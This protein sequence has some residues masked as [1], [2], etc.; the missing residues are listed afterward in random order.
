MTTCASVEAHASGSPRT[1]AST[2]PDKSRFRLFLKE[3]TELLESL[4]QDLADLARSA[5]KELLDLTSGGSAPTAV[6]RT[7]S[8]ME[9]APPP[10]PVPVPAPAPAPV[11]APTA[12]PP[13]LPPPSPPPAPAVDPAPAAA[14][15]APAA[16]AMAPAAPA[17]PVAPA[18]PTAPTSP[19]DAAAVSSGRGGDGGG[20][21]SR[22]GPFEMSETL[23]GEGGYGRV[24]LARHA[25][26]G[27]HVAVKMM[28]TNSPN[29][30]MREIHAMRVA[31]THEH[32]CGLRACFVSS[33]G[34]RFSLVLDLC[35]G[36]E[37]CALVNRYGALAEGDTWR[38]F[39]GMLAGVRHLHSM[40]IVHRDIKLENVLLGGPEQLTPK[41]CDF[42]LAHIYQRTADGL[43]F[44][45]VSLTQ[46]CGSRSYCPPEIMACMPYE[47]FRADLWSLAVALFAM[48][49]GFFPFEEATQRDW[50]F[51]RLAVL[52]LRG[53][54]TGEST[55]ACIYGF[56]SRPCPL[57]PALVELLDA[58][59]MLQPGRRMPLDDVATSAWVQGGPDAPARGLPPQPVAP[60]TAPDTAL[61]AGSARHGADIGADIGAAAAAMNDTFM[62]GD[63]VVNGMR[64]LEMAEVDGP[65]Y[66]E[67]RGRLGAHDG[68]HS[69]TTTAPPRLRRNK[70][71]SQ[72]VGVEEDAHDGSCDRRASARVQE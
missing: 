37:L 3:A 45:N 32:V 5:R 1:V 31:G 72:R 53:G 67:G 11:S 70:A 61:D 20:G 71:C 64:D 54:P 38:F 69:P 63:V 34:R 57:S 41:I 16:A 30:V 29:A 50:R 19:A 66:R 13:S 18:A 14:P 15:V 58:M 27:E 23:L 60:P 24:V 2:E 46:W 44:E 7:A 4:C 65:L 8:M 43:S 25:E 52:Q 62:E 39:R 10:P 6:S 55:T 26:S 21:A 17:A 68:A 9:A 28:H 40:G 47:G 22:L 35:T 56:Y 48:V 59:L 36:G 33:D 42:G 49:S 51:S 12:P